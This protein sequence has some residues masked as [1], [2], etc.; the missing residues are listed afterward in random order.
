MQTGWVGRNG[1]GWRGQWN[2]RRPDGKWRRCSTTTVATKGEAR[3]LLNLE[4]ARLEAGTAYM[5]PITLAELADRFLAQ[6]AAGPETV[7]FAGRRLVRPVAALGAA[8]AGDVT[9][10]AIQRVLADVPGK[11][12]RYD[13][14]RTLRMTYRFGVANRLVA[15]NPAAA[16]KIP[17]PRRSE[18]M[19]PFESWVE[20]EAVAEEAGRW[21][22]LI[23][24]MADTGARPGEAIRLEHRHVHGSRVELPG[25]KTAG[26]WRTV[27]MTSRG[28]QAVR[29]PPRA[30]WIRRVFNIAGRPISW[31]YFTREV[32]HPA[33]KLAGLEKRPPYSLRHTFAYWSL[34]AGVPIATLAREM[35]HASTERTF[36]VYGG[37][38]HEMGA[39]AAA[40]RESW[41]SGPHVALHEAETES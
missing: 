35:G 17:M 39:D 3:R 20:V 27:H 41:A 40:L 15:S 34:R 24:F 2:E 29:T 4:L 7:K 19:L 9:P 25:T 32:W 1:K 6:Y 33:L 28:V 21:G 26:A 36:A 30:M 18:R 23:V 11:A 5:P 8:Q 14:C 12:W 22:P 13:I 38:C 16:V 37:W 10:E 31:P